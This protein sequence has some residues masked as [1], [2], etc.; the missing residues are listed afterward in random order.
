MT[1]SA[2]QELV[3]PQYIAHFGLRSTPETFDAMVKWHCD[4]FGGR[5]V[6]ENP[7]VAMITF[8]DEHHRLNIIKHSSHFNIENK[9]QAVGIYHIAF[10]MKNLEELATSYEQAAISRTRSPRLYY[11]PHGR[12]STRE[13][14]LLESLP[15]AMPTIFMV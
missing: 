9:R 3:H 15:Q 11:Q 8:D 14:I 1:V 10:H 4:F 7:T 5:V 2:P 12:I 13:G 6:Y